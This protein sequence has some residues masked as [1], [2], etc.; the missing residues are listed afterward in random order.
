MKKIIVILVAIFATMF[1]CAN[2]QEV[3]RDGDNFTVEKVLHQSSDVQ[4]KYTFTVNDV[5]YPIWITKNGRCYIVR[6]SK[7]GKQYKQYLAKEICLEICK[8]LNVEY[9]E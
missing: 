1:I 4:T 8:E 2:A 3:K 5:V 6:T 9:K 7:N